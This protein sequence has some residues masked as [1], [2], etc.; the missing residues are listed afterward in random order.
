M[1]PFLSLIRALPWYAW[2]L[3][4]A[5]AWGGYG[6]IRANTL[7]GRIDRDA[8]A[9]AA[10]TADRERVAREAERKARDAEQR[11][12]ADN[13]ENVNEAERLAARM[14]DHA[15]AAAVAGAGLLER[16]RALAARCDRRPEAAAAAGAS[17]PAAGAGD[18]LA[19]V[20]G[21]LESA[22]RKLALEADKRRAAGLTC[23]RDA[24]SVRR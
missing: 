3:A 23:E 19:D 13:L 5:L 24:D 15:A 10:Q 12:A 17:A 8:A 21:R 7:Q 20:L 1:L 6:H 18:L 22:G 4:A 2:A 11:M 14:H 16:A 9:H